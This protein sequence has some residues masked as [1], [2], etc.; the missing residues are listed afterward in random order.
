MKR[1]SACLIL[2]LLA[3]PLMARDLLWQSLDSLG[4]GDRQLAEQTMYELF[5]DNPDQWPDWIDPA[6]LYVPVGRD[7][8][9]IVK[10]PV[11]EPCGQYKFTILSPVN[12]AQSRDKI[13]DFCAGE[14]DVLAVPNRDWPDFYVTQGYQQDANGDWQRADLR[15]RWRDGQWWKMN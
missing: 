6:A 14:L 9:L 12:G 15:L 2:L 11:H 13:G 5:G 1:F 3:G 8:A 4:G 10:R 7:Y